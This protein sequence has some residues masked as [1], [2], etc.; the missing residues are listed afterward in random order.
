MYAYAL[1]SLQTWSMDKLAKK[2]E[3]ARLVH[4]KKAM[5]KC[6]LKATCSFQ[7]YWSL[8]KQPEQILHTCMDTVN[9][10]FQSD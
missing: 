9:F 7:L 3:T 2:K 10:K 1:D 5:V 6:S 8:I 4:F